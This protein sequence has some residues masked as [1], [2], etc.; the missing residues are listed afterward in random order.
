MPARVLS[1]F[2]IGEVRGSWM[3]SYAEVIP[4]NSTA[5]L[6]RLGDQPRNAVP[7]KDFKY[8][9]SASCWEYSVSV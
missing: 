3:T 6:L 2:E 8:P 1:G 4:I 7:E 9:I 5:P